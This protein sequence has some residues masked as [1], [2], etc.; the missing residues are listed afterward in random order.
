MPQGERTATEKRHFERMLRSV[1]LLY[2]SASVL[3]LLDMSYFS[4]LYAATPALCAGMR[5]SERLGAASRFPH[6]LN[7]PARSVWP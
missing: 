2:I 1:N 7:D 3:I 4:R 6:S 5:M